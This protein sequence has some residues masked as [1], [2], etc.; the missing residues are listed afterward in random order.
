MPRAYS[1]ESVTGVLDWDHD[2]AGGIDGDLTVGLH[3]GGDI[4]RYGEQRVDAL[5][6]G[7]GLDDLALDEDL[8]LAIAGGHA[9]V[10]LACLARTVDDAAHNSHANR[11]G[12]IL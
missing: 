7:H 9:E 11:R 3:L 8:A 5:V 1:A 12:H 10:G 2:R 6:F 4:V